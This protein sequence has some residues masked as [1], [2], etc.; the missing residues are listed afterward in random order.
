MPAVFLAIEGE[1]AIT[2]REFAVLLAG[3]DAVGQYAAHGKFA[4]IGDNFLAQIHHA[5]ALGNDAPATLGKFLDG[6]SCRLSC[7]QGI[8]ML[9]G[10]TA[11]Q[12]EQRHIVKAWHIT[13]RIEE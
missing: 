2:Q 13:L 11:R 3:G 7:D 6:T 1:A 12:V 8:E 10:I 4:L 9:L 5:T